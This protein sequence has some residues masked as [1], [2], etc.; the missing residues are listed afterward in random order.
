MSCLT[1]SV[2][3]ASLRSGATASVSMTATRNPCR[4]RNLSTLSVMSLVPVWVE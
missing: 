3:Y 2:T 1:L 4:A